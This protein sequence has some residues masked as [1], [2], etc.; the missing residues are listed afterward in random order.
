MISFRIARH[1]DA[2]QL[3]QTRRNTVISNTTG[4]Y[5]DAI[6]HAWAPQITDER[7]SQEAKALEHPNRITIIAE[8]DTG[9]SKGTESSTMVIGICTIDVSKG[10]LQQCYVLPAY[11]GRGIARELVKQVETVAKERELSSLTVSSSLMATQFYQKQGYT[12]RYRY[13]YTLDNGLQMPCVMME[14]IF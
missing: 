14:K 1:A 7:I 4:I 13:D 3:L 6:L 5:T 11:H 12:E 2:E 9:Q 8:D 10:L